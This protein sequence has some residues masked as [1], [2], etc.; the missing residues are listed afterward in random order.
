[1]SGPKESEQRKF[2][3]N[4]L[5][6][7]IIDMMTTDEMI[8]E[9]IMAA[10]II[11]VVTIINEMPPADST[12]EEEITY[13]L[14]LPLITKTVEVVVRV[15]VIKDK[16]MIVIKMEAVSVLIEA[17]HDTIILVVQLVN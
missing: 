2:P 7:I 11:Q 4:Q 15:V 3:D 12:I 13:S 5:E 8:A 10:H 6:A 17:D 1:V 9:T 14:D 16:V